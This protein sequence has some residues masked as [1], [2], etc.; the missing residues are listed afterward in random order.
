[1]VTSGSEGI[2]LQLTIACMKQSNENLLWF[3]RA[4]S[5]HKSKA[6]SLKLVYMGE[7]KFTY[8]G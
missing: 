3:F 8:V 6:D 4:L 2:L 7:V 1:M 5:A